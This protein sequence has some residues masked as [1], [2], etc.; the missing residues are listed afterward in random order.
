MTL[1]YIAG[2]F[3]LGVLVAG[4]T[5]GVSPLLL[6]APLLALALV[7]VLLRR[8]PG[9][10]LALS[11]AGALLLGAARMAAVP[12]VIGPGS[13]GALAGRTAELRGV[14]AADPEVRERTLRV[15][16]AS[17]EVRDG[18]ALRQDPG[19]AWRPVAGDLLASVQPTARLVSERDEPYLRYGDLLE[20][21]GEVQAP[22]RF[23]EFDYR[24]YLARQG[25]GAVMYRP[26][27]RLLGE[28][29][30]FP[31]LAWLSDLRWRMARSL[32]EALPEPQA[33]LAQGMVLGL[34]AAIPQDVLKDFART[35]TTHILAISGLNIGIV[36][37]LVLPVSIW[38]LGRRRN[39]YLLLPLAVIWLYALLAGMEPPVARSVVM[40]SLYLAAL[41]LGRPGASAASLAFSVIL[42]LAIDPRSLWDVSFQLSFLAMAGLV[43]I[44]PLFSG[45]AYRWLGR[46]EPPGG[47]VRFL[48]EGVAASLGAILATG[49][50]IA[51]TF[52]LF[53][54]AGL[55]ATLLTAPALPPLLATSFLAALAGLVS[56]DAGTLAG[57]LAWPWLTYLVLVVKN[58]AALPLAAI[59]VGR[60]GTALVW[61]AYALLAL[62]VALSGL[63]LARLRAAVRQVWPAAQ[64]LALDPWVLLVLVA[65]CATAWTAALSVSDQRLR[66]RIVDV[67]G[68]PVVLVRSPEGHVVLVDGG[69]SSARV[70]EEL[71]K[72]MAFWER[73]VHLAVLTAPREDRLRG[74]M[75][76]IRR[77]RV[78]AVLEPPAT[79]RS[80]LYAE[81]RKALEERGVHRV[82]ARAGQVVPLGPGLALD[83]SRVEAD[84]L[85]VRVRSSDAEL[86]MTGG[87]SDGAILVLARRAGSLFPEPATLSRTARLVVVL[88]KGEPGPVEALKARL[89]D[90]RIVETGGRGAVDIVAEGLVLL[91]RVQN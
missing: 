76:V 11:M 40:G 43:A 91:A 87:A 48:V 70:T 58:F 23:Q 45:L 16:L 19:Q 27:L 4:R 62:A 54:P 83:I 59:E 3:V 26:R 69:P 38:A 85:T 34:R 33:A 44:S 17:I 12:D 29:W 42:L 66:L 55:P 14:V 75:E 37:G 31:P 36:L 18:A 21:R 60:I 13:V 84:S 79:S 64:S 77:Y 72:A 10:L 41:A 25:I 90:A 88:G 32:A 24:E 30:G 8:R 82:E 65:L 5:L 61:G 63:G 6:L 86:M 81:W 39:L 52:Q 78:Q 50:L 67:E 1:V 57:W 51:F 15:R 35:G 80:V 74:L 9:P 49:P 20:L 56:P 71:G 53:S 28:N 73:D 7:A 46:K 89:P 2:A 47:V 68:A 22:P